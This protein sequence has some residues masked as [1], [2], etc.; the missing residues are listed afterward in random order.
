MKLLVQPKH[1]QC[2]R[3]K[4]TSTLY[5]R[6]SEFLCLRSCL[7][8]LEWLPRHLQSLDVVFL[9]QGECFPNLALEHISQGLV[10]YFEA[11]SRR[12]SLASGLRD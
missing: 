5:R 2:S 6:I 12:L 8:H 1:S 10:A 3:H 7:Q 4:S 11:D 9:Q